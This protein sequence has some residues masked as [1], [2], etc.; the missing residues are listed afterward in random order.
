MIE[1]TFHPISTAPLDGSEVWLRNSMLGRPVK[2][3]YADYT[4]PWGSVSKQWVLT[5]DPLGELIGV[6][7]G[8][9]II[10][11]EWASAE[12]ETH[13]PKCDAEWPPKREEE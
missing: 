4:S 5:D 11:D 13:G 8:T 10:P 1:L 2:G 12:T 9:R 3:R 6:P 7:A